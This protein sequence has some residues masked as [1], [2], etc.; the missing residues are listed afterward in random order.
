MTPEGSTHVDTALTGTTSSNSRTAAGKVAVVA[1][2][3]NRFLRGLRAGFGHR[4]G[5]E[6]GHLQPVEVVGEGGVV[7]VEEYHGGATEL[8]TCDDGGAGGV[9]THD[10]TGYESAALTS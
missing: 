1:V 2:V 7:V 4:A 10:L 9:R 3:T 6:G 5:R 8:L